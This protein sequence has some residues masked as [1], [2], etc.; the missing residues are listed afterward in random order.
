MRTQ[1]KSSMR[2]TKPCRF[3]WTTLGC[4]ANPCSYQNLC[5]T[6]AVRRRPCKSPPNWHPPSSH[7]H[8]S[9]GSENKSL[10]SHMSELHLSE[11]VN[12]LI[13][14]TTLFHYLLPINWFVTTNIRD[15]ALSRHV[16][17]TRTGSRRKIFTTTGL[18]RTSQ[19]FL[20][21]E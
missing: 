21:G 11:T 9:Q 2:S 15:Q 4:L 3:W 12:Q 1:V 18:S 20:A 19:K 8:V 5:H 13:F 16:D 6:Y 10:N 14:A 7:R 17:T